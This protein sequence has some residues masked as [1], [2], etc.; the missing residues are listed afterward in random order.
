MA[1]CAAVEQFTMITPSNILKQ[2]PE[3]ISNFQPRLEIIFEFPA[4]C[5]KLFSSQ[6]SDFFAGYYLWHDR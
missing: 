1:L 3:I 2:W 4:N 5:R 6:L